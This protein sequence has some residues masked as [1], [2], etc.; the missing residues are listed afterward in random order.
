MSLTGS[1]VTAI[2]AA[3]KAKAVGAAADRITEVAQVQA[4]RLRGIL[5]DAKDAEYAR[6][7]VAHVLGE[8]AAYPPSKALRTIPLSTAADMSGGSVGIW[9]P[10]ARLVIELLWLNHADFSVWVR[11]VRFTGRVGGGTHEYEGAQGDEFVI[12]PRSDKKMTFAAHLRQNMPAPKFDTGRANLDLSVSA[13]VSGPWNDEAQVTRE[14]FRGGVW[15]PVFVEP[16]R[17]RMSDPTDVDLSLDAWF[18]GKAASARGG[19]ITMPLADIDRES[20]VVPGS[21]KRF[22][23]TIAERHGWEAKLGP[24]MAQVTQRRPATPAPLFQR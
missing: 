4:V 6:M 13:L 15:L 21:A 17:H 22:L 24:V 11:D 7:V 18:R 5:P 9:P 3:V 19:A 10:D 1:L 12:G 8:A 16:E 14:V 20:G 23:A 2:A